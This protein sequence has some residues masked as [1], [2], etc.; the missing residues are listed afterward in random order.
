[1]PWTTTTQ[2]TITWDVAG[3]TNAPVNTSHVNILLSTD[4]GM[5]YPIVLAANTPNDGSEQITVPGVNT[6]SG[7]IMV[8]AVNNIYFAINSAPISITGTVDTDDFEL[9]NFTVYPNPNN[10]T[11]TVAFD[12]QTTNDIKISVYDIRGRQILSEQYQNTGTFSQN[13]SL[14]NAEAG[15]YIVN[16]EDG[17]TTEIRKIII[18]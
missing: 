18:E 15:I 14:N 9:A 4:G 12:S 16:V 11:F 1:T 10:G 2:Q 7:R 5:T 17:N 13:I 3:T 6:N 8:E